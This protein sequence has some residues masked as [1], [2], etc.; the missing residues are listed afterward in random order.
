[1][2]TERNGRND[3]SDDCNIHP[4]RGH[5]LCRA[6]PPRNLLWS[7]ISLEDYQAQ[8]INWLSKRR[9]G[10]IVAPA[11]SGKTILVSGAINAVLTAK[12]RSRRAEI[13]WMANT[14]EQCQQARKALAEFP[15]I[16]NLSDVNVQCAA[17][18][19][20][21]S[22]AD[23]LVIDECHHGTAPLWHSQIMTAKGA[24]WGMTATPDTGD[25][26]R[27]AELRSIFEDVFVI[28]RSHVASR[29]S[30]ARVIL[31]SATDCGLDK[32]IDEQIATL[33]RQRIRWWKRSERASA[34]RLL[35]QAIKAQ[36][37]AGKLQAN[38]LLAALDAEIHMMCSW[39]SCVELGIIANR[40]RNESAIGAARRHIGECDRVLVLVNQVEHGKQVAAAI[41]EATLCNSK[42]G[43][44][45]R[46]TA[47][48]AFKSGACRC[49]V[50]TSLA[51]EGL[52]L[53][54]ANVL[55]LISGG[56]SNAKTEQRTGRVLRTFAGKDGATIYDFEDF[57]HPLMR[58]H[59]MARQS[60]YAKLGYDVERAGVAKKEERE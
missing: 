15:A 59:A 44:K 5:S 6:E 25:P 53:P 13:G 23:L 41:G 50:A 18:G 43:A 47:M 57:Q 14:I 58:K 39:Q 24:L 34:E 30:K 42:M 60:L 55:I 20:D 9:R 46:A 19:N 8:A 56:R 37:E 31:L 40:A 10:M 26:E 45:K 32:A 17:A 27:D 36:D 4:V 38:K 22:G 2:T 3:E 29:L 16:A 28:D 35:E 33:K 49:L 51:D 1:M 54:M 7:M 11:G 48:E 52:D 21:W 12:R